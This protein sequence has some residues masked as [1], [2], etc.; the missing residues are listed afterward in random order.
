[1]NFYDSII[2]GAGPAGLA[3]A[4]RLSM[5]GKK[6][7]I[8]ERQLTIGGLNTTY[9]RIH[10]KKKVFFDVG[11]HA[12][13]NFS[14]PGPSF[15]QRTLHKLLRQLRLSYQHLNLG[16]QNY[17]LIEVGSMTIQFSNSVSLLKEELVRNFPDSIE[18]LLAF[19]DE[20]EKT[21][22]FPEKRETF[23]SAK[24]WLEKK[25]SNPLLRQILLFPVLTYGSSWK[26]DI[27]FYL[28]I[29]LFK[30]MFYEGMCRPNGGIRT[31]WGEIVKK[32]EKEQVQLM[33]GEKVI[34]YGDFIFEDGAQVS[35]VDGKVGLEVKTNKNIYYTKEVYTSA[36]LIHTLENYNVIADGEKTEDLSEKLSFVEA[37]FKFDISLEEQKK[38]PT[39]TFF[40]KDQEITYEAPDGLVSFDWAVFCCP[41]SFQNQEE[42]SL[43]IV[44]MTIPANF[45]FWKK[46]KNQSISDYRRAKIELSN[47]L[48][49]M[50]QKHFKPL[51]N[52]FISYSDIFTPITVERYTGHKNGN[53]YGATRKCH[54][55]KVDFAKNVYI[56][57][58]D[59]G[60]PG[61]IGA[62]LSGVTTANRFGLNLSQSKEL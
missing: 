61:I 10:Q 49:S 6:V 8:L 53:I 56:I 28:Y 36:G 54:S 11:L 24:S 16:E 27:D 20:L 15:K 47:Q 46:L 3:C 13:T 44:R 32:L 55:G 59:Q 51:E 34:S 33:L 19:F 37:I 50:I 29:C 60:Y 9:E 2:I 7:A 42:E 58:A 40:A 5:S 12:M 18:E 14:P 4:L 25:I 17:S 62:M 43:G 35:N 41:G 23:K 39:L 1:M 57:G 30:S 22:E 21:N 48:L 38:L 26:N 45:D 31:I 52:K